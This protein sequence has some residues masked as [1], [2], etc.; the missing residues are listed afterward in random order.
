MVIQHAFFLKASIYYIDEWVEWEKPCW[1]WPSNADHR[2]PSALSYNSS[3]LQLSFPAPHPRA[4]CTLTG[5]AL[6]CFG[7]YLLDH[8][9][10]VLMRQCPAQQVCPWSTFAIRE[11]IP[12][13]YK[14][15]VIVRWVSARKLCP[16]LVC[17]CL[18][19][20]EYSG[21]YRNPIPLLI[22]GQK[23]SLPSINSML[24]DTSFSWP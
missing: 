7:A 6:L 17:V 3:S 15:S 23:N 9:P 8:F 11:G 21:M 22:Q 1:I 24:K 5:M 16:C 20:G 14:G 10:W 19:S 18:G 13:C 4:L 2:P 12:P